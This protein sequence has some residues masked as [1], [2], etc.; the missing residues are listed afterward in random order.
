M[1]VGKKGGEAMKDIFGNET[2]T[3]GGKISEKGM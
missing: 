3:G 2:G 1:T